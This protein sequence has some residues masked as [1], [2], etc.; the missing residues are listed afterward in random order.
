M[1]LYQI[2]NLIKR[3]GY[4][5]ILEGVNIDRSFSKICLCLFSWFSIKIKCNYK[6][7]QKIYK[8]RKN[9]K[10][11]GL[12][13][14]SFT[15]QK[16]SILKIQSLLQIIV[17]LTLTKNHCWTKIGKI[18]NKSKY[19]PNKWKKFMYLVIRKASQLWSYNHE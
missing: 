6:L 13:W 18:K 19:W 8:N 2:L 10:K 7:N 3:L 4:G 17:N 1:N 5:I 14:S 16:S 11:N 9:L 12:M 15:Q